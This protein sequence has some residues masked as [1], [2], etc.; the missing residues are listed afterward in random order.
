MNSSAMNSTAFE[1]IFGDLPNDW[2]YS[3][4]GQLVSEGKA[5]LQTGPFGTNLLASEYR[6]SGTPVIAVK[7]L[8]INQI[9]LDEDT[10][11]VDEETY[12]RLQGYR[13]VA[14]DIVFG[15][16]GAIDR[17]A[18]ITQREDGWL[19]GSDC[20]RLRFLSTG[21]SAK[22]VSYVL[23]SPQY[24]SWI[25]RNAG[26]STMP[27]LN[28]SILSRIPL[29]LPPP[30]EQH[31]IARIF[32]T[33]DDKIELNRQM[34]VTLEAT[35]RAIFQSWFMD[36]YP[37]R[38]KAEGRQPDGMDAETAALFPDSFEE[39]ELGLIPEGWRIVPLDETASYQNGLALQKFPPEGDE[40]LPVIKIRE[41][42]QGYADSNSDKATPNIKETCIVYDGDVLFSWSGSL[43]VDLWCGGVG[44]LNQHLFKVTSKHYPK[45]FYYYWTRHHLDD[46][47]SI[48][49][50]KTTTMGHIQRY[51]LSSVLVV[52]PPHNVLSEMTRIMQPL[53]DEIVQLRLQSRNLIEIRDTLLP[54]LIS[55]ELRVNS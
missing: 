43:M 3:S 51:H 30:H 52:V 26:G 48:A 49:A 14:G 32:G 34:N 37:V 29:P 50:D 6:K 20:I 12:Q 18:Y 1:T 4:I 10:P 7:N 17:R 21:I 44:A 36:F 8:G 23:G 13:L 16:K 45:W 2:Q 35:T 47:I 38:A 41:L 19:Q 54:K 46:F 39:S 22:Y 15:R 24:L 25:S 31:E 53:L 42:R 9:I 27:S 33:L 40:F 28:Q 11:R 55:G 5:H